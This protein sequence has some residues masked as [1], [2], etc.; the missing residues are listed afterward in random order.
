MLQLQ[1][2]NARGA[3]GRGKA[4]GGVLTIVHESRVGMGRAC[5][6]YTS[7]PFQATCAGR[8]SL[9]WVCLSSGLNM[10]CAI[11]EYRTSMICIATLHQTRVLGVP[12]G[13]ADARKD[14]VMVRI[15]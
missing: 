10:M 5:S 1:G 12:D 8:G 14:A 3:P 13:P 4:A 11:K 15:R 2:R 7:Y 9:G 6:A